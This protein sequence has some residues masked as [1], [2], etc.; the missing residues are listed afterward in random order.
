MFQV[1]LGDGVT[2]K[3]KSKFI[4]SRHYIS[5]VFLKISG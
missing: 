5:S 1:L 3:P 4:N 2:D